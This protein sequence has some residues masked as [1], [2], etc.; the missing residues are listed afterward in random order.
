MARCGLGRGT[1]VLEIGP[2]TGQATRPLLAHGATVTAVEVG[3][4]LAARL[5][6]QLGRARL[7]VVLGD[8]PNALPTV[9]L[10]A[11]GFDLAVSA[12]AFHWL[13]AGEAIPALARVVRPS[14]W[15]ALWWTVYGDPEAIQP[16]RIGLD[17]LFARLLP[18]ERRDLAEIP[19]AMQT[20]QRTAEIE[21][22]GWFGP[23]SAELIRWEHQLTPPTAR[24]LFATF[25]NIAELPATER[26]GFLDAVADLVASQPGGAVTD[27][28]VTAMYLAPRTAHEAP[29]HR[30]R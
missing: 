22:G 21:E 30:R 19:P 2:G 14:G 29:P 3:P 12:T 25:S 5:R 9:A 24:A 26:S 20:R 7:T 18:A 27:R 11:G 23:A 17:A 15:L 1:A 16:W 10:P 8:F 4:A 13:D 6:D 28:Y